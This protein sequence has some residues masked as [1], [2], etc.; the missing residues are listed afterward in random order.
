[1]PRSGATLVLLLLVA[2]W[3]GALRSPALP[4]ELPAAQALPLGL[5]LLALGLALGPWL[6]STRAGQ[7][8]TRLAGMDLFGGRR[9][10]FLLFAYLALRLPL[11]R[12]ESYGADPDA[13]RVAASALR[14][15][16]D[17]TYAVSRFPGYPVVEIGLA[18][19]LALG[20]A[21]GA[22]LAISLISFAGLWSFDR[23]GRRLGSPIMGLATLCLAVSPLFV[24]SSSSVMDYAVALTGLLGSLLA[25]ADGHSGRAGALLGLAF[26]SRVTSAAFGLPFLLW[27]RAT[28]APWRLP[29]SFGIVAAISGIL[30]FSPVLAVSGSRFLNLPP[31][32][33]D[34]PQAAQA[35]LA[36]TGLLPLL[37]LGFALGD[38]LR[39]L[40]PLPSP[41]VGTPTLNRGLALSVLLL[42]LAI[43]SRLPLQ[44]GYLLPA[45]AA[46]VLLLSLSVRAPSLLVVTLATVFAFSHEETPGSVRMEIAARADQME[47]VRFVTAI[48]VEPHAIVI[49]GGAQYAVVEGL[50][51]GL[52]EPPTDRWGRGRWEE[53]RDLTFVPR[54]SKRSF[55]RAREAGQPVYV[56]SEQVDAWT[57]KIYGYSPIEAGAELLTAQRAAIASEQGQ[58]SWQAPRALARFVEA[59]GAELRLQGAPESPTRACLK[60]FVPVARAGHASGK[61]TLLSGA[62]EAASLRVELTW[63]DA[64]GANVGTRRLVN[65]RAPGDGV[66]LDEPLDPP[67]TAKTARLCAQVQGDGAV[68]VLAGLSLGPG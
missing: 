33:P 66:S 3:S 45:L 42:S 1:M 56:W 17:Q 10:I 68:A 27:S 7:A 55:E 36:T 50:P 41:A 5:A 49:L 53:A 58:S 18:P 19:V 60:P 51:L 30:A 57:K 20:G 65:L 39:G 38:A 28:G 15:W 9:P 22:K 54:L 48:A 25:L 47:R 64:Q 52:R 14:V 40:A 31:A 13:W 35:V 34:A 43:F 11:L 67:A 63:K 2:L 37:A 6:A 12:G 46:G 24:I 59:D 16:T 21:V 26:G 8:V 29:L 62:D 4:D 32:A 23:L 61:V 44:A